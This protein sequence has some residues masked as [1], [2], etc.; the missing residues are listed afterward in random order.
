MNGAVRPAERW[1]AFLPFPE[2]MRGEI[3]LDRVDVLARPQD[4]VVAPAAVGEVR[5]GVVD[6]VIGADRAD[7]VHV[8]RA[9][10]AG[11]LCAE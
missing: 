8:P 1:L 10:Y 2:A 6:D 3:D 9:A 4:Q 7:H 11:H 5:A